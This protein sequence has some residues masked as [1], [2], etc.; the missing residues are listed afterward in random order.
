MRAD[1]NVTLYVGARPG[2]NAAAMEGAG[3]EQEERKTVFAGNL[4]PNQNMPL[5][6]RIAEK[7]AKAQEKAMKIIGDTFHTDL[8]IDE[9]ME[10]SRQHV[11]ELTKEQVALRGELDD[12]AKRRETL[13]KAKADG[14]VNEEEYRTEMEILR[15]EEMVQNQKLGQNQ[16]Q[17]QGENASIR[18]TRRERLKYHHMV[19]AQNS[20]DA[21]MDAAGDE[22]LGMLQQEGMDRI[23]EEA[24][25]REEQAEEIKEEREEKKEL[26]EER[27]E[28]REEA[29]A[30][31]E[32]LTPEE[33]S[34]LTMSSEDV[35]KEVQDML[36]KMNLLDEDLKGA[37]VDESL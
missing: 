16:G 24:E 10:E 23:D 17:I 25:K 1:N 19:N 5:Q 29:E 8:K 2:A 21:V 34:E 27:K 12:I 13:E 7:K 4:N 22:I 15:Q 14:E 35:Q 33:F 6:D 20:A 3:R 11:K 31:I 26:L 28:K 32:E 9:G 30:W 18:G 36:R 37:A